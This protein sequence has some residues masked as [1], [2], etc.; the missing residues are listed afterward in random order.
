MTEL[1]NY[2]KRL[3][4]KFEELQDAVDESTLDKLVAII[5]KEK[6]AELA[7]TIL[8]NSGNKIM[9]IYEK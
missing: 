8:T 6:K 3:K 5:I 9:L 7:N 2:I 1:T 4:T